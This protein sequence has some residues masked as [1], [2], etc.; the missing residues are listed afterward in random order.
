MVEDAVDAMPGTGCAVR[1][2]DRAQGNEVLFKVSDNFLGIDKD[3]ISDILEP[4][5]PS[6]GSARARSLASGSATAGHAGV[7]IVR[8]QQSTGARYD[9]VDLSP[10]PFD[11]FVCIG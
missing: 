10:D 11:R 5:S 1:G 8:A 2:L 9:A 6:G 4:S 7:V 3:D